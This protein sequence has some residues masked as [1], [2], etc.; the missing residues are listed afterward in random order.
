MSVLRDSC[1]HFLCNLAQAVVLHVF[2]VALSKEESHQR[3]ECAWDVAVERF[4]ATLLLV[5]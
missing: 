2:L 4:S 3:S 1:D 5:Q